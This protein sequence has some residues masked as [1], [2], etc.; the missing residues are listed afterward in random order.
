MRDV[1]KSKEQ[2]CLTYSFFVMHRRKHGRASDHVFVFIN[3]ESHVSLPPP[4]FNFWDWHILFW[5][6]LCWHLTLSAF[7][8][9][10]CAPS[11]EMSSFR[12]EETFSKKRWRNL[13]LSVGL[14]L[15]PLPALVGN[16]RVYG[17]WGMLVG[18]YNPLYI[19]HSVITYQSW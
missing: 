5:Q 3:A 17:G 13:N 4:M 9:N 15:A 14:L 18:Y 1:S 12:K 16:N 6:N 7:V 11:A 2:I 19:T 10:Y 8:S